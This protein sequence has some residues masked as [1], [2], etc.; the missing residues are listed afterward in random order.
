MPPQPRAAPAW[1]ALTDPAPTPP[2]A[3]QASL[4]ADARRSAECPQISG[5]PPSDHLNRSVMQAAICVHPFLSACICVS[6]S[7]RPHKPG[8]AAE[9]HH[10]TARPAFLAFRPNQTRLALYPPAPPSASPSKTP[11]GTRTPRAPIDYHAGAT[12][13]H[14]RGQTHPPASARPAPSLP[15]RETRPPAA[16]PA[17]REP[18]AAYLH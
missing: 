5:E 1:H 6:A 11:A 8:P 12:L 17:P 2:S 7:C 14:T 3:K 18:P 10:A 15:T 9:A 4:N 16:T 13:P